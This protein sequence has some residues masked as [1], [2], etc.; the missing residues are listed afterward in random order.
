[1]GFRAVVQALDMQEIRSCLRLV[2]GAA[3]ITVGELDSCE[4]ELR[5]C[6]VGWIYGSP[7]KPRNVS[8]GK[9]T[10]VWKE[11]FR[12]PLCHAPLFCLRAAAHGMAE[13]EYV[14]TPRHAID[15]S[16]AMCDPAR[17]HAR[18]V[19]FPPALRNHRGSTE[20]GW[21]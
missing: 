3:D 16:C 14:S 4:A 21:P 20:R 2:R 7:N 12:D 5:T 1:M 9:V 8:G 18:F 11:P 15:G 17:G 13:P 19:E 6:E 10:A